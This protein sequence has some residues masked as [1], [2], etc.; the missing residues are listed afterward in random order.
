MY[1]TVGILKKAI[2]AVYR[3]Q[4]IQFRILIGD[5][6]L[7]LGWMRSSFLNL[8][9]I[10]RFFVQGHRVPNVMNRYLQKIR[11]FRTKHTKTGL[12]ANTKP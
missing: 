7:N 12:G 4:W 5:L 3:R 2:L 11:A 9:F 8:D 10:F 1:L 6:I